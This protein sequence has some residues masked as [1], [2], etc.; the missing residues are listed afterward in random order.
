MSE[1]TREEMNNLVKLAVD[2]HNGCTEKY[3]VAQSQEALRKALVEANGGS[4][5]LN[6]KNIR[7]GKCS[8]LFTLIEEILDK[9]TMEGLQ[10]NDFFNT[11]V[12]YRNLAAGDKNV[13][14]LPDTTLFV[15]DESAD[16]T[17]A[18]RRQRLSGSEEISIPTSMK[19]VRIYE[20]LSRVLSGRVD[21]NTMIDNVSKSFQQKILNDIYTVWA[22]LTATDYRDAVYFSTKGS[23]DEDA[24]LDLIAHVEAAA[25]GGQAMILGT[26]KA[27]RALQ[28]SI[29][30]DSAKEDI[31][32]TGYMGKFFGTPVMAIPQRHQI[33]TT[34]F[35]MDDDVLTIVVGDGGKPIKFVRE[36]D[37]L[38]IMGDPFQNMDLTQEYF[39]AE[40]YGIGFVF[41]GNANAGIG[42]YEIG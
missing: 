24:L 9:T 25:N 27:L 17:Q 36:G 26:K 13:F 10:E 19:S 2:A 34:D 8:A 3:S 14:I 28:P 37:P 31:Y 35:V 33:G 16:G 42:H 7:D 40:R 32:N 41:A 22:G 12:E 5:V 6:Y 21:F 39:Y 11:F 38:M 15:V 4:T 18:V 30:A 23:Y 20:E 1:I 29:M